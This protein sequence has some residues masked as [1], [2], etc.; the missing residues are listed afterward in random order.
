MITKRELLGLAPDGCSTGSLAQGQEHACRGNR[1]SL[2]A[3]TDPRLREFPK[4]KPATDFHN[5]PSMTPYGQ[6]CCLTTTQRPVFGVP[7][8]AERLSP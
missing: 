2:R 1:K 6:Q 7:C 3:T 8:A 5:W 4:Q